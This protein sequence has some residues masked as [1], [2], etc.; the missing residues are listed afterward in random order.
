MCVST[1][2]RSIENLRI[3]NWAICTCT[4]I[5]SIT[6]SQGLFSHVSVTLCLRKTVTSKKSYTLGRR[7][8][9]KKMGGVTT[10][11][12]KTRQLFDT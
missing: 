9:N 10:R 2:T 8:V 12:I 3:N 6:M 7:N 1:A 5:R 4:Y 11:E